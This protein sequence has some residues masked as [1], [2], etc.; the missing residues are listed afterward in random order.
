MK[1]VKALGGS[2]TPISRGE[3]YASLQQGEV[4]GA[5]NNPPSLFLSKHYEI[6]KYYSLDEHAVFQMT[7]RRHTFVEQTKSY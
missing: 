6:C 5:E 3:L 1:K 7:Y 4:D 2:P